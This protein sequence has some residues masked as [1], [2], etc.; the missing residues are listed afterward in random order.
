MPKNVP[1]TDEKRRDILRQLTLAEQGEAAAQNSVGAKLAQGYFV[2]RNLAGALYWYV[3]AVKQ[4]YT[5]AKF[6]AGIMLIMGE[7]V[8]PADVG[9][10]M[11]LVRQAAE[12]GDPSARNFLSQCYSQGSFGLA[13]DLDMSKHWCGWSDAP[14]VEYGE[15]IDL[16]AGG[17]VLSK[18]SIEWPDSKA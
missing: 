18:P 3:Q 14:F 10:G 1:D 16:E 17:L 12:A 2:S 8:T 7:G 15:P 4:G 9:L 11:S 6:N 13:R 5:H